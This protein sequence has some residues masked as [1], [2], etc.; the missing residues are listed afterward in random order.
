M[1]KSSGNVDASLRRKCRH[2]D[3]VRPSMDAAFMDVF[4]T[5]KNVGW[6]LATIPCKNLEYGKVVHS[7]IHSIGLVLIE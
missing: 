5:V 6:Q 7:D 3:M 1:Q 4:A 2:M